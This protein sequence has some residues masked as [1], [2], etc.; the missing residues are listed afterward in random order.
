MVKIKARRRYSF[1][2]LH[3]YEPATLLQTRSTLKKTGSH[4][5][6]ITSVIHFQP[7]SPLE[8]AQEPFKH[9]VNLLAVTE[10]A[11]LRLLISTMCP[12]PDRQLFSHVP[13]PLSAVTSLP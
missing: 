8:S 7:I 2:P 13:T 1:L 4:Y 12:L 9:K 10:R 11:T 5:S 3:S 6:L